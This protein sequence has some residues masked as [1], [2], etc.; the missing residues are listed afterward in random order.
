MRISWKLILYL[1]LKWAVD[2]DFTEL[3]GFF[4]FCCCCCSC[5]SCRR[6]ITNC[7]FF[8]LTCF[9]PQKR[10]WMS[11]QSPNDMCLFYFDLFMTWKSFSIFIEFQ[12]IIHTFSMTN[13]YALTNQLLLHS[14]YFGNALIIHGFILSK[15]FIVD[16]W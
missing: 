4:L 15:E 2:L 10:K 6:L 7:F 16:K 11:H 9:D 5:F 13:I 8:S 14:Q 12:T 1:L 3:V